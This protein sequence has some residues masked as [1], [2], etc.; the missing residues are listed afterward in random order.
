MHAF[1]NG[2]YQHG[3]D[4]YRDI[5]YRIELERGLDPMEDWWSPGE[6]LFYLVPGTVAELAL[7]TE[8]LP[9][10]DVRQIV[11]QERHRREVMQEAIPTD[12]PLDPQTLGSDGRLSCETRRSA[13]HHCRVSLVYR[14]GARHV[15]CPAGTLL[16]DRPLRP[17]SAGDWGVRLA[18]VPGHGVE[19]ISGCGR[20]ARVQH[21]RC[22]TMVHPCRG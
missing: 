4:W 15:Y 12:D 6:W 9:F 7:T 11:A 2:Q 1:H 19:S 13:N 3:P 14:L 22:I 17:G 5:Q 10:A 20:A 16:S 8:E 21:G 18:S